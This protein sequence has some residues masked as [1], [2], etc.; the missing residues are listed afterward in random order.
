MKQLFFIVCLCL[1]GCQQ[2][3]TKK[4]NI[5]N[6]QK[7]AN[8]IPKTFV[9]FDSIFAEKPNYIAIGFDFPVGKPTAKGY[10]NAQ[11]FTENNHLGDDWNGTGGGNSDLGDSI[12]A[13]GNGYVNF[14]ENIGGGW[15]NI[16]RIIHKYKGKYYESLYAHCEKI[17]VKKG[18]F[19]TKGM[20]I[21]TIGNVNGTYYAHLHLEIR[22][23]ILM[24]VGNGYSKNTVGYVN[25]TQFIT[26]NRK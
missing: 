25:P 8:V 10:Y 7:K 24:D 5:K 3:T 9:F 26:S 21:G 1:F 23:S 2:T 14:A 15:G 18:N 17:S 11:K 19:V 16:I 20:Q 13:I 12:Y 6:T 4:N 22:D